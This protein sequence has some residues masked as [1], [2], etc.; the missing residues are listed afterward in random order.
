MIS[1]SNILVIFLEM[2][3]VFLIVSYFSYKCVRLFKLT[4]SPRNVLSVVQQLGPEMCCPQM[5]LCSDICGD[6]RDL[7][8]GWV[9]K[10]DG[11]G[12]GMGVGKVLRG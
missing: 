5:L 10:R 3:T 7:G 12:M 11:D 1:P 6:V 4:T 9:I 2:C 8:K